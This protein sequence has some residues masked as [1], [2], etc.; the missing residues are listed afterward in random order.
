MGDIKQIMPSPADKPFLEV[1][2]YLES[3][4]IPLHIISH[5][6]DEGILYQEKNGNAV[7]VTAQNDF[8]ELHST[9][10]GAHVCRKTSMNR[11]WHI[12]NSNTPPMW[13][14]I[15][16]TAIDAISLMLL[17]EQ[18]GDTDPAV[19]ISTGGIGA[20][21]VINRIKKRMRAVVAVGNTPEG[22]ELRI[23]NLR[24]CPF[25]LTPARGSW[26]EDLIAGDLNGAYR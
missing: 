6:E 7:F 16:E 11:F 4:N 5:M 9:K 18:A 19:F 24:D 14:F 20:Q 8:F 3:R 2:Q 10:N 17:R 21:A 15:C 13:A 22:E 25:P 26:N 12:R 1:R 23:N